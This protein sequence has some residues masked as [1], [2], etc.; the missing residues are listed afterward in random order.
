MLPHVGLVYGSAFDNAVFARFYAVSKSIE[1]F[2]RKEQEKTR[3]NAQAI[4]I[5]IGTPTSSQ[6]NI[7]SNLAFLLRILI[8][9]PL[10]SLGLH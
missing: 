3:E 10:R 4:R 7:I 6:S 2:L 5:I 9:L 1:Y 8:Q